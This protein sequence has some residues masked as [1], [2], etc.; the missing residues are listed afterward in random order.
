M[1][2]LH[3]ID[4]SSIIGAKYNTSQGYPVKTF[5]LAWVVWWLILAPRSQADD[6][7]PGYWE[8]S[9]LPQTGLATFY[10]PGVMEYVAD[11][12]QKRG[13]LPVCTECVGAVALLRAGDIGRKVWLQPTDGEPVGPFLVV[14]CAHHED[15]P[16]LLARN[17]VVDVSFE[18]GQLWGMDRPLPG[19]T[20]LEDPADA[21]SEVVTGVPTPFYV[22]ADRVVLSTPTPTGQP[23]AIR[24]PT[25]WAP[26]SPVPLTSGSRN[27][28]AETPAA[29]SGP[30]PLTPIITTPTPRI[31]PTATP[32]PTDWL[33]SPTPPEPAIGRPGARL[34][35]TPTSTPTTTPNLPP[36]PT[37][38]VRSVVTPRI[39]S[40]PILNPA[41]TPTPALTPSPD[42]PGLLRLWRVFLGLLGR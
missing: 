28:P 33:P 10:A 18:V 23:L 19:V 9:P 31:W 2:S 42:E 29:P 27:V 8:R 37:P 32:A 13:Q 25:R 22:P 36:S 6:L 34:F 30:P 12:R 20:V 5:L 41:G 1:S 14:D 21:T 7:Q 4:R 39:T 15:I 3:R 38:T 26:R 35:Q 17:W 24:E 11:Y 16:L 40:A